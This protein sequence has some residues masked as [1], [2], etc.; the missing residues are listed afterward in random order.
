MA[1]SAMG[2]KLIRAV[3]TPEDIYQS[4]RDFR[5]DLSLLSE[6]RATLTKKYPDKWIA[7]YDGKM[8]SKADTIDELLVDIDRAGLPRDKV[9]TQ[10]LG[11]KKITML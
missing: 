10:F 8:T 4:L 5:K 3:G 9:V 7:F 2:R 6:Q 1:I 11:T